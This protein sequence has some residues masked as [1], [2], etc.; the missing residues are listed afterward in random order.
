MYEKAAFTQTKKKDSLESGT[1]KP[2]LQS[3]DV[4]ARGGMLTSLLHD[5]ACL[6]KQNAVLGK[7][8][9]RNLRVSCVSRYVQHF[10]YSLCMYVYL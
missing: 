9:C 1:H 8:H 2:E 3:C 5:T 4:R 7:S 10:M 6:K